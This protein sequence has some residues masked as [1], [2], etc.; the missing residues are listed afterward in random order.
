MKRSLC[1]IFAFAI[2]V[3][4]AFAGSP[5]ESAKKALPNFPYSQGWF[6]AD[7][8]YSVPLSE[9]KSLW[10]FGDTFVAGPDVTERSKYKEMIRNSIGI[11]TCEPGKEC[12]MQYFWSNQGTDKPR[13][14]FDTGTDAEWLWP[15]DAY[16]DGNTLYM[17]AMIVRNKKGAGPQDAFGFEIAGTSWFVLSNVLD[18]PDKWKITSKDITGDK[19]WA[20]NSIFADG[21]YVMMYSQVVAGEGKGH[22]TVLRVPRSK[23]AAPDKNWE[24]LGADNKW[25]AG[26]PNGDN[27]HVIEQAISE[28]SVRYHPSIKKWV[29]ISGGL[30]FPSNHILLRT[31]DSPIGPWSKPQVIFD[32]PEMDPKNPVY[33]KETFCYATKE[34]VEFESSNL[35]ITYACN[36]MSLSKVVA[37]MKLYRPQV[38]V[39]DLPK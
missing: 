13:S 35:V 34:H 1:L 8:A 26:M 30:E 32:F 21:K 6:G 4:I 14:F 18:A 39:L 9:M 23:L 5:Q 29:A 2:I 15:L 3:Q 33:D 24:Y 16:R 27:N 25:H 37:N 31:A 19:L 36:S 28:M 12:T 11:S 20:G 17:S 38:V 22:M 10:L 7:D